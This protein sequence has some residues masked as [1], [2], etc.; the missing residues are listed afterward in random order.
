MK[1]IFVNQ[2]QQ[3]VTDGSITDPVVIGLLEEYDKLLNTSL[4]TISKMAKDLF[5]KA[6]IDGVDA[7]QKIV[8]AE[9]S[10]HVPLVTAILHQIDRD[11]M[12]LKEPFNDPDKNDRG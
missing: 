10:R 2:I 9:I 4:S 11:M 6:Y 1:P 3:Q 5:A 8:M 7:A 12:K